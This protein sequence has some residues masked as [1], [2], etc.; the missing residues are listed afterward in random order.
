MIIS[1]A[2]WQKL[3]NDIEIQLKLDSNI[4]D[5]SINYQVKIVKNKNYLRFNVK[6]EQ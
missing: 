2:A 1:I 6:I 4:S 3:K 5:V